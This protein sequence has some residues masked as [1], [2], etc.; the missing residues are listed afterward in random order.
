MGLLKGNGATVAA[1]VAGQDYAAAQH[2]HALSDLPVT[3]SD[4]DLAAG[5]DALTTN[6]LY[7]VY[8]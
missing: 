7:I 2:G 8:E 5:E 3:V 1:A 4:T 6:A